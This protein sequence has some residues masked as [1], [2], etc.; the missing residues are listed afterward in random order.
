MTILSD[1]NKLILSWRLKVLQQLQP[2]SQNEIICV[3]S[4][5]LDLPNWWVLQGEQYRVVKNLL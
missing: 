2:Y 5:T 1:V 4:S 3:A